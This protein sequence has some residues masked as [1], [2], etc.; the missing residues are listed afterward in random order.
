M[1]STAQCNQPDGGTQGLEGP[2]IVQGDGTLLLDMGHPLAEECR[3]FLAP[4]AQLEKSPEHMHTYRISTLT[5]WNAMASGLAASAILEGLEARSRYSLPGSVATMVREAGRKWGLLRLLPDE[6]GSL[7]LESR[8]AGLLGELMASPV[9]E[10]R[11]VLEPGGTTARLSDASRGPIK[12]E[13]LKLGYPVEDLVGYAEGEPL[14]VNLREITRSGK[15]FSMRDY[16]QQAVE[17]FHA[18]GAVTGGSGVLCLPCGAGK[19][20]IGIGAI[21]RVRQAT[22]I[23][24]ANTTSVRQWMREILERTDL[25][26][27]QVGEYSGHQ[28]SIRPVTVATYQIVTGGEKHLSLFS[29]RD[30]GLIIYDEVHLLPAPVFRLTADLQARRRLGL[31]ATLVREDGLEG[32]IFSMIGPKRFD[33]PWKELEREGWIAPARCVEVRVGL[34]TGDRMAYLGAPGREQARL[35]AE[36]P[37]KLQV[38]EELLHRHPQDR[39]LIFGHYLSQLEAIGQR[40]GAPVITGKMPQRRRELYFSA[41][42]EGK[43]RILI[44]SRVGNF[45]LDLP[46][47]N[48]AIQLSGT[49]GSRQEEAQ[50]LGR[51]LRPKSD[52]TQAT[53]YTVVSSDSVE[54]EFAHNRQRFLVEQGYPYSLWIWEEQERPKAPVVSLEA[55]RLGRG[56]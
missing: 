28:K 24:C 27:E 45:S 36:N 40:V 11:L 39:I 37:E 21:A 32:E 33:M 46:D 55:Y 30:W 15:S 1:R 13:L 7:L 12:R 53:F 51:L 2:L 20:L 18:G 23:L 6:A 8:E 47:A 34:P 10:A 5:L 50:R 26:E 29:E 54:E 25:S 14:A 41:F 38:L 56:G 31:T 4:I 16:Q 19:T 9:L 22:L 49:F 52:G 35:A 43:E 42:R 48:V 3:Q 17:S 44:L